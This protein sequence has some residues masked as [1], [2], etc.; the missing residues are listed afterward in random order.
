MSNW[1]APGSIF[2]GTHFKVS[3]PNDAADVVVCVHGI[4]S[5][6]SCFDPIAATL[7]SR[8]YRVIQYDLIGRGFSS[9]S[10]RGRYD[11]E[12]HVSQLEALITHLGLE[13]FHV[14]GHSMGGALSTLY[15]VKNSSKVASLTLIAPAGLMDSFPLSLAKG[16]LQSSLRSFL[17]SRS[18]QE[19]A[20]RNDFYLKTG[21]SKEREDEMV[22]TM[23]KM[24]DNNPEAFNAFFRSVVEF[25]LYGLE[26]TVAS[27]GKLK[28]M[29]VNLIWGKKDKAVPYTNYKR[30]AE[31]LVREGHEVRMAKHDKAGHGLMVEFHEEIAEQIH[32]F[33]KISSHATMK[34]GE[35]V[36]LDW[37][38][39]IFK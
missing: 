5:F 18:G 4:G 3:G 16:C 34:D 8:G 14:V 22:E 31:I 12:A 17:S 35:E 13:R 32:G 7:S 38:Y 6:H 21:K 36:K 28:D 2:N 39:F 26:E 19:N 15:T 20:W 10:P 27:L 1:I 24:Y 29:S 23:H 33:I 25:P 9:P 37:T 30:W 11:A